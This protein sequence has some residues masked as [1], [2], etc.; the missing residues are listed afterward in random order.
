MLHIAVCDDDKFYID[1]LE[2]SIRA[3]LRE[4]KVEEYEIDSYD[5]A[6]ELCDNA[7]KY[8]V[9]FLDINM[10]EVNGIQA[11]EKIREMR[12]EVL[13]VFVTAFMDFV[14]QGYRVRA[15][16]FLVKDMLE[17]MLPECM[18][19]IVKDMALQTDK[20][21]FHFSEGEKELPVKE[22][23]YIESRKHKCFF[24]IGKEIYSL[25]E[26]LDNIETKLSPYRFLR[27]H[28]SFLVNTAYVADISCYRVKMK[29]GKELPIPREKYQKVRAKFYEIKGDLL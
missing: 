16:R 26:K 19:A 25:Y 9:I 21:E 28:K 29:N 17:E 4:R 1:K 11:A 8:N 23:S 10:P 13:L 3:S 18:D 7:G 5:S 6:L 15:I 2:N 24:T 12:P 20:M 22:I 27:V 14:L